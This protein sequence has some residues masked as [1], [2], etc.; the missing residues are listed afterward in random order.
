M[1]V[2]RRRYFGAGLQREIERLEA[3]SVAFSD[4]LAAEAKVLS[5][6][7]GLKM[8]DAGCGPGAISRWIAKLVAPSKVIGLDDDPSFV[9]AARK[10]A[11]RQHV[12]NVEFREGDIHKMEFEDATFDLAYC[13]LVLPFL[14]NPL[15]ALLE[16]KRVTRPGGR[17]AVADFAGMFAY[18]E[19]KVGL[20]SSEKISRF[21]NRSQRSWSNNYDGEKLMKRGRFRR[22][23]TYS[24]P[25]FASQQNHDHLQEL[26]EPVIMQQD[27]YGDGA[28]KAKFISRKQLQLGKRDLG[29]FLADPESFWMALIVL[30]VGLV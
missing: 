10:E 1:C 6:K 29:R 22:I 14:S 21:L 9:L 30:R 12:R 18:P 7:P 23:E 3:Q 24:L 15:K 11:E 20:G 25:D 13:R 2:R 17:V 19:P 4:E 28:A 16:L 27:V 8:L 26:L 5:L